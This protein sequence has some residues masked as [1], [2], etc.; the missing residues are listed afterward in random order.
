SQPGG[1]KR[2]S[3]DVEVEIRVPSNRV[4]DMLL[5]ETFKAVRQSGLARTPDPEVVLKRLTAD[6][7]VY[8]VR[9]WYFPDQLSPSV[10]AGMV[11]K[12]LHNVLW[13]N[14]VPLPVTQIE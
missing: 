14:E 6:A 5:G 10:A 1:A 7:V 11:L 13:L 9:F 8:E 2:G 3:V 12:A 4:M